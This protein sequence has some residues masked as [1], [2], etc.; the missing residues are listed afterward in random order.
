MNQ[1][2]YGSL[3]AM[4]RALAAT[5]H[6]EDWTAVRERMLLNSHPNAADLFDRLM[7][8]SEIDGICRRAWSGPNA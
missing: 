6:Y 5:G 3:L 1:P 4:A 8:Q 7:V 2:D